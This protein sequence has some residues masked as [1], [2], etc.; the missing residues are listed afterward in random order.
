MRGFALQGLLAM[1]LGLGPGLETFGT[2]T[3]LEAAQ[4]LGTQAFVTGT[5]RCPTDTRRCFGIALHVVHIEGEPVQTPAW[6]ALHVAAANRLF[7]PIGVGFEVVSVAEAPAEKADMITRKDRDL[8][9]RREH[10]RGVIHVYIVRKLG[11]V[12][13]PG[14]VIRGVH[15]RD[16]ADTSRRWVILS[17]IASPLVLPHELGHFFGL[18]HSTYDVSIMNKTPRALP[19]W[20]DRL[21]AEPELTKMRQRRDSMVQDKTLVERP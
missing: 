15:W 19:A 16:R 10:S 6:F 14:E 1:A 8:L 17:S 4:R 21:F 12:D 7:D 20:E 3:L 18:P 2:V 11:D 9:G 13:I 5:G